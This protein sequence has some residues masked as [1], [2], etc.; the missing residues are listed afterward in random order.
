MMGGNIIVD[1]RLLMAYERLTAIGQAGEKKS[2]YVD[3]FWEEMLKDPELMEE[4][5]YYLDNKT[6]QDKYKCRG[7]GLTDM[8]FLNLRKVEIKQ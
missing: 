8:Y 1:R 5:I 7:Y 3:G 4:F 2:E 6:F